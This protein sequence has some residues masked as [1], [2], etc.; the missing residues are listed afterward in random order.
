MNEEQ[1]LK[2]MIETIKYDDI[3]NKD[4]LLGILRNS[5]I[6]FNKSSSFTKKSYQ[7]WENIDLRVPIPMLKISRTL[8][9]EF[10]DLARMIYIES[11]EYD[12]YN[13]EIKPKP[14]DLEDVDYKEHDVVFNEIQDTIIQGIRN[15][16]YIIWVA[17]AWF[18]DRT[19]FDELLLRK[20]AGVDIRV[21][22]SDESSNLYLLS[23]IE[24]AF[25]TVKVPLS[26]SSLSNRLHDKFCIIDLEYV[27]HGSYNWSKNAQNND[28]TLATALDRDLV[29]SFADEFIRLFTK[30]KC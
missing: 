16:K 10:Y 14:V 19:I 11:D 26:G 8:E 18:T 28:E 21:I 17:V 1:F 9:K 4:E 22:T 13:L 2:T 3:G 23:E 20:E 12:F 27:M 5:I 24:E 15:S 7:C 6:T 30:H 29:K 25:E